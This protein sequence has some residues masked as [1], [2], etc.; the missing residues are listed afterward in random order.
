VIS[1][2]RK[3]AILPTTVMRTLRT[4]GQLISKI[5]KADNPLHSQKGS[6]PDP[7]ETTSG[8]GKSWDVAFGSSH[9]LHVSQAHV[10]SNNNLKNLQKEGKYA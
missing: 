7:S 3:A 1:D 8:K 6:S 2:I 5:T 9:K 10:T 4:H